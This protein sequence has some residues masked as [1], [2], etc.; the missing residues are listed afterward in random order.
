MVK[1]DGE[2]RHNATAASEQESK[3][4][5]CSF[6]GASGRYYDYA[7]LDFKN[8][9]AFPIGGGNY[10]FARLTGGVLEV[11]CAGETDSMWSIFV[12][13]KLWEIAKKQYGATTP[14][15]HPNPDQRARR[16]ESLDIVT[17]YSPP[18]NV[19]LRIKQDS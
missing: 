4:S 8:R 14:Y 11:L 6:E 1:V 18:M 3:M 13:T 12:S 15:I 2:H 10:V 19:E 7:S 9:A 16:M 17:K 5:L